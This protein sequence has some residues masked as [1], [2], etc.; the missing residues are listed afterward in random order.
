MPSVLIHG[1]IVE[2]SPC[3]R[4][5]DDHNF[6]C[7]LP[8]VFDARTEKALVLIAFWFGGGVIFGLPEPLILW[9]HLAFY[10]FYH[11]FSSGWDLRGKR[12]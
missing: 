9:V 12:I 1:M 3:L 7:Y 4:S 8:H 2:A 6:P 11:S 5:L 10:P